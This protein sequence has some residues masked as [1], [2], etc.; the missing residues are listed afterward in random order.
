MVSPDSNM[1]WCNLKSGAQ[2]NDRYS[3]VRKLG[4][5]I[6]SNAWLAFDKWSVY[7]QVTR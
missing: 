4:W 3:V 2:L 5:G 7:F 1:G 6:N